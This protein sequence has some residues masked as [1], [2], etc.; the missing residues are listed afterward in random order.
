MYKKHCMNDALDILQYE[1]VSL[2]FKDS[3]N[4]N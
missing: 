1:F 4:N 3:V 2:T